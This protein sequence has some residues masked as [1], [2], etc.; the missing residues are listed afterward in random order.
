[1]L[2]I[3]DIVRTSYGSG[4][5]RIVRIMRGCRCPDYLIQIDC[6]GT[7]CG[8]ELNCDDNCP[9]TANQKPHMHLVCVRADEPIRDRYSD[10]KLYWLNGYQE[11]PDGIIRCVWK[12]N[13][14]LI[15]EGVATG[16]QLRLF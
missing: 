5:Y 10:S 6:D 14:Y 2:E 15:I 16:S 12:P 4:P 1:M 13:D 8:H 11:D 9:L 3:G 7:P